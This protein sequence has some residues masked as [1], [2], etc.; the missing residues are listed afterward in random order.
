MLLTSVHRRRRVQLR[1]RK[2][3]QVPAVDEDPAWIIR[4]TGIGPLPHRVTGSLFMLGSVGW[5][6]LGPVTS[7]DHA[8]V[9]LRASRAAPPGFRARNGLSGGA[10]NARGAV[11]GST[12][13]HPVTFVTEVIAR[14]QDRAVPCRA[15]GRRFSPGEGVQAVLWSWLSGGPS[16]A[17]VR[18]LAAGAGRYCSPHQVVGADPYHRGARPRLSA[19]AAAAVTAHKREA[20]D[21]DL[22]GVGR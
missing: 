3:G 8:L 11:H 15:A 19:S 2:R 5:V 6:S 14:L 20:A 10:Y 18:A 17:T 12:G 7:D 22:D 21:L 16:S 1:R 4:E 13:P 9:I